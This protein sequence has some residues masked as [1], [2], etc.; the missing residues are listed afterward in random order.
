MWKNR[1]IFGFIFILAFA[2]IYT[3]GG[4]VPYT[5]FYM[6]AG[7][8]LTSGLYAYILY[9]GL[10]FGISLDRLNAV[11]GESLTFRFTARNRLKLFIPYLHI[12]FTLPYAVLTGL[13]PCLSFSL[14]P[15]AKRERSCELPCRY[16]GEYEIG[17][18]RVEIE[19]FLGIFR[20]SAKI[21]DIYR[22]RVYPRILSLGSFAMRAD[23]SPESE[24][25]TD[26]K[27][28][29]VT[30]ISDI[31]KYLAGDSSRKVHW[32]LTAKLNELMVKNNQATSDQRNVIL[33]DLNRYG[34]SAAVS[35]AVADK[36]VEALVAVIWYGVNRR[37]LTSLVYF[38]PEAQGVVEI[39][40]RDAAD[41]M[42]VFEFLTSASFNQTLSY[43]ELLRLFS[44]EAV[45]PMNI[46]SFTSC[47]DTANLTRGIDQFRRSGHDVT[48]IHVSP[49]PGTETER[50]HGSGKISEIS[51]AEEIRTMASE[52]GV[53]AFV[54][55]TGTE[56]DSA[57]ERGPET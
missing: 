22:V 41:F 46:F 13:D 33:L 44:G 56:T 31:R 50:K 7:V 8:L 48:L 57:L 30:M 2:F 49:E 23:M 40:V 11:K 10:E 12:R 47:T 32:K 34:H 25:I 16:R 54:L 27:G 3:N 9:L 39:Q 15:G 4:K 37:I 35:A 5:L 6:V 45:N 18:E 43:Q 38:S 55:D 19:D 20:F 51:L 52:T 1:L 24:S 21:P 14:L 36:M 42:T 28:E 17:V 53:R 29:D 26:R